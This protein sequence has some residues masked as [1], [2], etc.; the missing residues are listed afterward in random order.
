[1]RT[2][3]SRALPARTQFV[4][5]T[6]AGGNLA[7]A[8]LPPRPPSKD[9]WFL[10]TWVLCVQVGCFGYYGFVL[11]R[12]LLSLVLCKWW[13]SLPPWDIMLRVGLIPPSLGRGA[14]GWGASR[15]E[16][17]ISYQTIIRRTQQ[18]RVGACPPP[19][20]LH[21]LRYIISIISY[22]LVFICYSSALLITAIIHKISIDNE[23]V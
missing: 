15:R 3:V 4:R 18:C 17:M 21:S 7:E 9:F 1:M 11:V 12:D 6:P 23:K 20:F 22:L 10:V 2:P 19:L 5:C 13:G 8:R 14:G 16:M